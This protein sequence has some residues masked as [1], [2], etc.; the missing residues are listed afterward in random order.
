MFKYFS[1]FVFYITFNVL[2]AQSP[3]VITKQNFNVN[4]NS[5]SIYT[6]VYNLITIPKPIEDGNQIWDYSFL[7]KD[8]IGN[9]YINISANSNFPN[10]LCKVDS[11]FELIALSRGYFYSE[12]LY[13]DDNGFYAK[14]ISLG[15]QTGSLYG[16]TFN[17]NDSMICPEQIFIYPSPRPIYYFPYTF[18]NVFKSSWIRKTNYSLTITSYG[19]NKVPASKVSG[20]NIIDSVSGWGKL[21]LPGILKNT[22]PIEV[23]LSRRI[24]VETDS[25][26][27]GGN[28]APKALLDAFNI[29]QG[30]ISSYSRYLFTRENHKTPLLVI[31]YSDSN[32]TKISSVTWDKSADLLTDIND[33]QFNHTQPDIQISPNPVTNYLNIKG[34]NIKLIQI[35]SVVG[36]KVLESDFAENIPVADLAAGMYFCKITT[37]NNIISKKFVVVR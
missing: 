29:A 13:L 14:G 33:R 36:V 30:Q 37:G 10:S 18:G 24:V 8:G 26:F 11:L 9:N 4:T 3:L 2:S 12:Y 15:N 28:P 20:F 1:L 21:I 32:F 23:L 5:D 27:V 25:F 35:Y 7:K 17:P 6:Q 19:L 22:S 31:E 34:D 16:L